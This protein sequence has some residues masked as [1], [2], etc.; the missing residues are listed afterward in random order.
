[1]CGVYRH[2]LFSCLALY[3]GQRRRGV[4]WSTD[5]NQGNAGWITPRCGGL[6]RGGNLLQPCRRSHVLSMLSLCSRLFYAMVW[7]YFYSHYFY[8]N[9][10]K[11]EKRLKF[12]AFL[13]LNRSY[14]LNLRHK[15][16]LKGRCSNSRAAYMLAIYICRFQAQL[17]KKQYHLRRKCSISYPLL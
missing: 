17:L 3:I 8:D 7:V 4:S 16:C 1:M 11:A 5:E 15:V 6:N 12:K 2:R 13:C 9:S 14:Y 10:Q